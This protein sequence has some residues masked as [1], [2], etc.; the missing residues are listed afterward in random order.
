MLDGEADLVFESAQDA[1]ATGGVAY[2]PAGFEHT[3]RNATT[4]PVTYVM[5]KW[6]GVGRADSNEAHT[7][8]VVA[9]P[10]GDG[11]KTGVSSLAC[12]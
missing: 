3:L 10:R 5:F 9:L 7:A 11:L 8:T 4:S 1:L 6:L 2:Y 12:P